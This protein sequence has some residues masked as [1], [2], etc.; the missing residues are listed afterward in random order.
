MAEVEK[1][2]DIVNI[3]IERNVFNINGNK[4]EDGDKIFAAFIWQMIGER[5]NHFSANDALN[6]IMKAGTDQEALQAL[7]PWAQKQ[8]EE[9]ALLELLKK[10]GLYDDDLEDFPIITESEDGKL[11][12]ETKSYS[13]DAKVVYSSQEQDHFCGPAK[14]HIE[15]ISVEQKDA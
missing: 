8:R 11:H 3:N 2:I 7:P 6:E 12:I 14:F 9:K 5:L 10:R 13:V 15:I 1:N 4:I